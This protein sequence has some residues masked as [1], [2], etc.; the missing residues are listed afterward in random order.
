MAESYELTDAHSIIQQ[1]NAALDG[2]AFLEV[3][4]LL[5]ELP[6]TD[7]AHLLESTP[8]KTRNLIWRLINHEREG[9][10]LQHLNEEIRN[11]FA[12]NMPLEQLTQAISKMETDDLADVVGE[13]PKDLSSKVLA[14]MDERDRQRVT[15]ALVYPEDTA[16]GLMNTDTVTVTSDVSVEVVLRYLRI[17]GLPKSTASIYVVDDD[18]HFLGSLDLSTLITSQSDLLVESIM[19]TQIEAIPVSMPENEVAHIFE[20]RDLLSAPVINEDNQLLGRITIDDVVDVIREEAEHSLMSMAGLDEADDTFAPVWVSVRKRAIWLGINLMTVLIATQVIGLFE[21]TIKMITALAII[22]PIVPSMGGVAGTQTLTLVIRG[23]SLGHIG[24]SN[25]RWLLMKEFS[26]SFLNGLLWAVVIAILIYF[27]FY[28]LDQ[29]TQT[30]AI[31]LAIAIGGAMLCSL[32]V[33]A[34]TGASLP[35]IMRKLD[36]DPVLS[37]GVILTTVTDV[38]GFFS[39]LGIAT[40]LFG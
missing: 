17:K 1:L 38:V 39:L 7:I 12:D 5:N 26:V 2:H 37:G 30:D 3:R 15:E 40:L 32:V 20:R 6:A 11:K 23:L 33:G 9:D 10:I 18:A 25:S 8:P 24:R 14:T 21:D 29:Y 16:G 19:D 36:M 35:L 28:G 27:W 31:N 4:R 13:L 34:V 22:Q